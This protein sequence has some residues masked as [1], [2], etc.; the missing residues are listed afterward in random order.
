M[1]PLLATTGAPLGDVDDVAIAELRAATGRR[2]GP[3]IVP[4]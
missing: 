1:A 4:A 2:P 3:V